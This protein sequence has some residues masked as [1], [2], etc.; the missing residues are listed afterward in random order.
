MCK[1][2]YRVSFLFLF[3]LM[4]FSLSKTAQGHKEIPEIIPISV[5]LVEYS[6]HEGEMVDISSIDIKLPQ[7]TLKNLELRIKDIRAEHE[8]VKEI[9]GSSE[10]HEKMSSNE[11]VQALAVQINITESMRLSSIYIHAKAAGSQS[12][13]IYLKLQG[14]D[15]ESHCPNST[16][17]GGPIEVNISSST[18]WYEQKFPSPFHVS[19]GQYFIVLDGRSTEGDF[20]NYF[21]SHNDTP[22][23]YSSYYEEDDLWESRGKNSPFSYKLRIIHNNSYLPEEVDACMELK[24][25]KYPINDSGITNLNDLNLKIESDTLNLNFAHNS[26][27]QLKFNLAYNASLMNELHASGI[28]TLSDHQP[29][30]WNVKPPFSKCG[31]D[32]HA[33][34]HIPE[35]WYDVHVYRNGLDVSETVLIE[36]YLMLVSNSSIDSN[37]EWEIRAISQNSKCEIQYSENEWDPNKQICFYVHTPSISGNVTFK[38]IDH[39]KQ[40]YHEE[41]KPVVSNMTHF[42]Y[43]ITPEI[44]TGIYEAIFIW[45]NGTDVGFQTRSFYL[46]GINPPESSSFLAIVIIIGLISIFM[47]ISIYAMTKVKEIDYF[48]HKIEDTKEF[49]DIIHLKYIIVSQK[50]SGLN[51]YE[52]YISGDKTKSEF[53]SSYMSAINSFGLDVFDADEDF[54]V[55]KIEFE[56]YFILMLNAQH[57]RIIYAMSK[58]PSY[59]FLST[60]KEIAKDID[61]TYGSLFENFKGKRDDFKS[62]ANLIERHIPLALLYPFRIAYPKYP[63]LTVEE[64]KIIIKAR[65]IMSLHQTRYIHAHSLLGSPIKRVDI[66][67]I[68]KLIEKGI[69]IPIKYN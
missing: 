37:D 35:N 30:Q 33:E 43:S 23:L 64:R 18:N 48:K 31:Y 45:Q 25:I 63:A 40:V 16:I 54:P 9:V 62:I 32:Y 49:E 6:S 3:I 5:F 34:F 28:L 21:W 29:I 19:K 26:S 41:I 24:N 13:P 36:D 57:S 52:Q 2:Y 22:Q 39:Q 20:T 61:L 69:F 68:T 42:S 1:K 27:D 65:E 44:S 56:D 51:V 53:I 12:E 14:Y 55:L 46:N 47:G 59:K 11:D 8:E 60:M 4:L 67:R 17:Y 58:N 50:I 66:T 38:L 7:W 10:N 15:S